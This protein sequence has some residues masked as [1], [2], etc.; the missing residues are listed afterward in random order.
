MKKL[1]FYSGNAKLPNNIH[2]FS[3]P[4]SHSCPFAK[5]CRSSADKY[6]GKIKDYKFTSF[7][8]YAASDESRYPNVRKVRWHN[9]DLIKEAKTIEQI[10]ELIQKSLPEKA[11]IIRLHVSGDFYNQTYFDAWLDVAKANPH[12]LF[13]AYTKAL[14]LWSK[15]LNDI[16]KNFILTAS[17]GGTDDDLITKYGLRSAK[18]VFSEKEAKDANLKLDHN[19]SLAM[20]N[21][22][23]FA[24]LLHGAQPLG[25]EAAKA[26]S[27]LKLIGKGGYSRK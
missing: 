13:Y 23:D 20:K 27:A 5:T 25:S 18:V 22:K 11:E 24:L 14:K 26:W 17:E 7:R 4:A 6:T 1:K 2:T 16:P 21:G 3:L 15:R 8:C 12:I 19:D 9:F 10:K